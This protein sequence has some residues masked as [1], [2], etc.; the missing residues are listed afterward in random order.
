MVFLFS[1]A[2][3]LVVKS[4]IVTNNRCY[5]DKSL[6]LKNLLF[7]WFQVRVIWLLVWWSLEAYM[8]VNFRTH[9]I[10]QGM[11]KLARTPM[12][13]KKR[14]CLLLYFKKEIFLKKFFVLNNF[15]CFLIVLICW[16]KKKFDAFYT[17]NILKSNTITIPGRALG[18]FLI[19]RCK[20]FLFK[21]L[22]KQ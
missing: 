11:R 19:L 16:Y 8:V 13:I 3:A 2:A 1:F 22:L 14:A 9:E 15:L 6:W 21:N 7:M 4:L 18:A 20:V 12:L 10:S 5:S 17:K